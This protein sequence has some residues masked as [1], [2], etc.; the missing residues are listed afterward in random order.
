MHVLEY[1]LTQWEQALCPT[2]DSLLKLA[3]V[4]DELPAP[5]GSVGIFVFEAVG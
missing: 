1:A 5:K 4:R 2:L 3:T